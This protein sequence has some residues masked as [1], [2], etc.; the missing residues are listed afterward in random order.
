MLLDFKVLPER[1]AELTG[2]V[3]ADGTARIQTIYNREQNPFLWDLLILLDEKYGIKALINTSF[4]AQG[5][6]IVHTEDD[7]LKAACKM[8]ISGVVLNGKFRQ[9]P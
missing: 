1:R 9:L 7:A 5:E 2:A 8:G 6:P 4:N 3:H